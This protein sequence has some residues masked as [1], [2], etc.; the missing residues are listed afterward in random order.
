VVL[1]NAANTVVGFGLP[2]FRRNNDGAPPG[3]AW[4]SVLDTDPGA[5]LRGYAILHYGARCPLP[6]NQ[7]ENPT[8]PQ[9]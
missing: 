1:V 2:G 6:R 3:S 4:N 7:D 9:H 5:G 8:T